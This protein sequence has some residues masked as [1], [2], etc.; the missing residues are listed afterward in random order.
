MG[1]TL[2]I[3]CCAQAI[4]HVLL[5][6]FAEYKLF[7]ECVLAYMLSFGYIKYKITLTNVFNIQ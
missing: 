5:F 1:S 7:F 4:Q 2:H 3:D 6:F